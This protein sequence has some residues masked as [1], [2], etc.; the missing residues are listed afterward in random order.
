M[1]WARI[2]HGGRTAFM[3][4]NGP[5]NGQISR[6]DIQQHHVVP[7]VVVT[8]RISKQVIHCTSLSRF[9]YHDQQDRQIF[10][11]INH[12]WD[13]LDSRVRQSDPPP[14]EQREPFLAL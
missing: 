7:L 2:H 12:L 9:S 10:P 14:Q 1:V 13:I 6:D 3:R 8:G 11:L 5:L 4:V